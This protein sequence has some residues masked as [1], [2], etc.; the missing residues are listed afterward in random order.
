ML[1]CL[2]ACTLA[3][4]DML[5][6]AWNIGCQSLSLPHTSC[7]RLIQS[8][9]QLIMQGL[10]VSSVVPPAVTLFQPKYSDSWH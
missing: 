6:C 9:P 3:L 7:S 5:G 8:C 10:Y 4:A 1:A 2:P